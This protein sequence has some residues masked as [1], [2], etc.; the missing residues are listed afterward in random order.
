MPCQSVTPFLHWVHGYPS[1]RVFTAYG[2]TQLF[3]NS[4]ARQ[5]DCTTRGSASNTPCCSCVVPLAAD[6]KLTYWTKEETPFLSLPPPAMNL[7]AW[8]DPFVI[9]RPD[10]SNGCGH[11]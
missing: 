3:A 9:G 5:Q 2:T 6:P 4:T 7:T 8:R 11:W 1:S 10:P